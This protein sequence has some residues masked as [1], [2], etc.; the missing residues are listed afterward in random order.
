MLCQNLCVFGDVQTGKLQ[1]FAW[2]RLAVWAWR[3]CA[4]LFAMRVHPG[5]QLPADSCTNAGEVLPTEPILPAQ[6]GIGRGDRS[7]VAAQTRCGASSAPR[8]RS[9]A[10]AE[11]QR[12]TVQTRGSESW[13][14]P[15]AQKVRCGRQQQYEGQLLVLLLLDE[16]L[17]CPMPWLATPAPLVLDAVLRPLLLRPWQGP[18]TQTP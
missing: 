4:P 14:T 10:A 5:T 18:D 2:L 7:V 13:S 12:S 6:P 11:G 1:V 8:E 9:C 15:A 3:S 16:E 17:R